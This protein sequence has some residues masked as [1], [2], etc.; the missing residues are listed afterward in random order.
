MEKN[1]TDKKKSAPIPANKRTRVC[2][3]GPMPPAKAGRSTNAYVSSFAPAPA[4]VR[5]P[6][7]P[8]YP[9][10]VAPYPYDRPAHVMYGS[11]SPPYHYSPEAA[12]PPAMAGPYSGA[13][14]SYPAYGYNNG[15]APTY[16]QV[17][18]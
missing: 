5:S 1:K 13:P 3:N 4:Y 17:Y 6:S 15:M 2:N 10:G 18:Y 9:A 16:P 12:P 11:S 14:I 8:Q 7:H